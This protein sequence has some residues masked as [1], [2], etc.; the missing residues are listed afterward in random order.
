[1]GCCIILIG[2]G[3]CLGG[4]LVDTVS[5]CLNGDFCRTVIS[6]LVQIEKASALPACTDNTFVAAGNGYV[7]LII[8]GEAD[9]IPYELSSN[10]MS[11]GL[12]CCMPRPV[13]FR[14]MKR[15]TFS[16]G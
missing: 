5:L 6:P 11:I 4:S 3:E 13:T 2:V 7:A 8:F 15:G 10:T 12:V 1:M 14:R 16:F 9:T